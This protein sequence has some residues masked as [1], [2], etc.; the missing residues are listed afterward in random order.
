MLR[1]LT[2]NKW[3]IGVIIALVLLLALIRAFE[4]K[5][6]Y[7]PFSAYF[8]GDYLNLAFPEYKSMALFCGMGFRYWLNST[9]SLA[10][11][12]VLFS[13]FNLT[14]FAAV[15][16]LIF[17]VILITAFFSL[18]HFS[19]NT[20]NFVLF[21]VRRFLIQPMFLLLFVPAFYY[22]QRRNFNH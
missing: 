7:D 21:Y 20:N 6:F 19:D 2:N 1:E 16:Y 3:K 10:I 22:Q 5:L 14:K 18:L 8:K 9:L 17:F 11:I 12:Y 15:L 13:D 4:D